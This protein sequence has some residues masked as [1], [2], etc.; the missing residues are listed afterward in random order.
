MKPYVIGKY[1][2]W[3]RNSWLKRKSAGG[4]RN[5]RKNSVAASPEMAKKENG[6]NGEIGREER[7]SAAAAK[8]LGIAEKQ[9]I[10]KCLAALISEHRR[11][12][13]ALGMLAKKKYAKR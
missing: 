9:F 7:I 11:S 4:W 10:V 2:K 1:R 6:G 12:S 5:Q 13:M 8:Y 3:R